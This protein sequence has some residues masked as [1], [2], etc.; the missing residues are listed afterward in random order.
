MYSTGPQAGGTQS[1][2]QAPIR[3]SRSRHGPVPSR[4]NRTSSGDSPRC[5]LSG[6]PP[7]AAAIARK[8]LGR[9]RVRR[10][11]HDSGTQATRPMAA[12]PG[13]ASRCLPARRDRRARK[14]RSSK[15]TAADNRSRPAARR[16]RACCVTS[17]TSVVPLARASAIA[18]TTAAFRQL[19]ACRLRCWIELPSAARRSAVSPRPA[20][21]R[22]AARVHAST[23]TRG[24]CAR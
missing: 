9:D 12:R 3:S 24:A 21:H 6:R 14:P 15:N 13:A 5:T 8:R 2:A 7:A 22:P 18:A 19:R 20:S 17:P 4:R 1:D 10:M 16:P 23:T 11:R